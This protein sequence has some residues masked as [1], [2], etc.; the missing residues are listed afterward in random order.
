MANCKLSGFTLVE[1]LITLVITAIIAM[2]SIVFFN[3]ISEGKQ[4][5]DQYANGLAKL[6]K[7]MLLIEQDFQQIINRFSR[8]EHGDMQPFFEVIQ[9]NNAIIIKLTRTGW[10]NPLGFSRSNIQ[11]VYYQFSENFLKRYYWTVLDRA[12]DS[13]PVEQILFDNLEGF[14]VRFLNKS[15][16]WQDEWQPGAY[17]LEDDVE[18][19]TRSLPLAIEITINYPPYGEIKRYFPL[20]EF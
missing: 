4:Q 1:I 12:Q 8:D 17:T 10:R 14:V 5:L 16:E 3:N 9:D 2:G 6:Q 18:S 19:A 11:V 15:N 13:K 20:I 7:S